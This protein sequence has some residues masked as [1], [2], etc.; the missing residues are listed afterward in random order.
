[1]IRY[2]FRKDITLAP[3]L[4]TA[5]KH[6]RGKRD[7]LHKVSDQFLNRKIKGVQMVSNCLHLQSSKKILPFL[8]PYQTRHPKLLT[9]NI[10]DLQ[11]HITRS[12]FCLYLDHVSCYRMSMACL[13]PCNHKIFQAYVAI[14][15]HLFS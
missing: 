9:D 3:T 15:L 10:L 4:S 13:H 11:P 8:A 6:A 14:L 1:M 7:L 5:R 12:C 2:N